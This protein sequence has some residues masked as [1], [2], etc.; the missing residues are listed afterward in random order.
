[1]VTKNENK[2]LP[3]M[4]SWFRDTYPEL[5]PLM[6]FVPRATNS[7][8][9]V[10]ANYGSA[11]IIILYPANAYSSLC[12]QVLDK[13]RQSEQQMRWRVLAEHAGNKCVMVRDLLGFA[14]AVEGYL[15]NTPYE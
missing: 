7:L 12:I 9:K 8:F 11:D 1:M 2:M 13:V 6:V 5:E 14:R 15:I 4:V 10:G 3:E